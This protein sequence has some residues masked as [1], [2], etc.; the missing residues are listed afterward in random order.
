MNRFYSIPTKSKLNFWK[1]GAILFFVFLVFEILLSASEKI[2]LSKTNLIAV[3]WP[4]ELEFCGEP[5]PLEDFYIREAWEKEFLVLLASDYQ[6]ILYLKRAPKFFPTIE[7]E[8]RKRGMPDDLKYLAVAESALREDVTSFAD[9]VGLWQFIP[10]TARDWGLRVDSEIDERNYFEKATP[11][12]L[13]YLQFL[14]DKFDSWTLAAAAYN[15][16]ENGLARRLDSQNVAD[17]Y[18]LY[19]N[20]ETSQYLFR[21]LAIKEIMNSPEKYGLEIPTE[22]RF[23]WPDFELKNVIGPIPD[24]AIFANENGTTL[25]AIKELNPWIVGES[26]PNGYFAVK[27]LF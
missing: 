9:A 8:L 25:R 15:S 7:S 20:N 11:A 27:I 3:D 19:L 6:N 12:A 14:H 10:S 22:A 13:D 18:D 24:L 5:V 26:L 2:L 4:D 17:Y 16:G 23:A 21:I 1:L